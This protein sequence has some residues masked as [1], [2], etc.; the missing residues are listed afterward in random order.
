MSLEHELR[1]AGAGIPELDSTVL[2]SG[3][4]PVGV[5]G[6]GNRQHEITVSLKRLDTLAA[7]GT[8]VGTGSGAE[9]PHLDRAVQATTDELL[10][11]RRECNRVNGILVAIWAF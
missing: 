8:G 2:G 9:L 7:F 5:G 6:E 1:R 3:Q 4:H 10:A 11:A